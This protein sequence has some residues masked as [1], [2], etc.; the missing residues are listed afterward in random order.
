MSEC[1]VK[2]VRGLAK[3]MMEPLES[4][5]EEASGER[6][7]KDTVFTAQPLEK[8]GY[9]DVLDKRQKQNCTKA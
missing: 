6:K 5:K 3:S 1:Q 2:A 4:I 9:R 8:G 7:E